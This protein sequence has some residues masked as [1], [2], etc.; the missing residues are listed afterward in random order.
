MRN[1]AMSEAL[2]PTL[3]IFEVMLRNRVHFALAD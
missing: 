3:A 2:Y 1:L